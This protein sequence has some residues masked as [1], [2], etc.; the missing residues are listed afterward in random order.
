[1]GKG[2]WARWTCSR[3]GATRELRGALSLAQPDFSSAAYQTGADAGLVAAVLIPGDEE[4]AGLDAV[5]D[6][7]TTIENVTS[8]DE[9][10]WE[11]I[12]RKSLGSDGGESEIGI[13]R[14][15]DEAISRVHR[16]TREG[17]VIHQHQEHIGK[18]GDERSFPNEW[19]QYP[20]ITP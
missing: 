15:D 19:I 11:W 2:L 10:T 9:S 13:E 18:Y 14:Q 5:D 7:G 12:K 4:A 1:L 8:S 17:E 6:L 3:A 16:V 20:E